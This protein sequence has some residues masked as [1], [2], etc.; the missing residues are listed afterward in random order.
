MANL[1]QN[2]DKYK[3]TRTK[4]GPKSRHTNLEGNET[5]TL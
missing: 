3:S 2:E 4:Q 1:G 5:D